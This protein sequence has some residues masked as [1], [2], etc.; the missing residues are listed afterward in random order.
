MDNAKLVAEGRKLLAAST[1]T[2]GPQRAHRVNVSIDSILADWARNNLA[3][4]LDA[5]EEATRLREAA[6]D[7]YERG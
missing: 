6:M 4:L 7:P 2:G 3:A 1:T 5:A